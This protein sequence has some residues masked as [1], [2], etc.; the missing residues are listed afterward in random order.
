MSDW[1]QFTE[2]ARQWWLSDGFTVCGYMLDVA[3]RAGEGSRA[4]TLDKLTDLL[5]NHIGQYEPHGGSYLVRDL[6]HRAVE[7]VEY[8]KLA[9]L[10]L[11]YREE[12]E[13]KLAQ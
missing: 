13:G 11:E 9:E 8:R 5:H 7:I 12:N 2:A 6:M 4:L 1:N 3:L 10:I